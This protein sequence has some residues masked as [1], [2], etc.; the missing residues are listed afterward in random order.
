MWLAEVVATKLY[1]AKHVFML[2]ISLWQEH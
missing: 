1:C 2:F